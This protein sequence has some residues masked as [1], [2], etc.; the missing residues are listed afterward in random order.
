MTAA[1]R[2]VPHTVLT[3]DASD[4]LAFWE[5][6]YAELQ[7][8]STNFVG[9]MYCT[10]VHEYY[11]DNPLVTWWETTSVDGSEVALEDIDSTE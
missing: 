10:I 11:Y 4:T 8:I 1:D 3:L 9:C 6:G 2:R 7:I 5:V